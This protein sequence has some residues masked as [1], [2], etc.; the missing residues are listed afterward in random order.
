[1][2]AGLVLASAVGLGGQTVSVAH[3]R[4]TEPRVL[5]LVEQGIA[6]SATFRRLIDALNASD[7][8]VYI[9]PK[10]HRPALGGYLS[11]RMVARGGTR[12]LKIAV[13]VRGGEERVIALVAHELQHAV[14][15]AQSPAVRDSVSMSH[16]FEQAS[17]GDSC[18]GCFE[19]AAAIEMQERVLA[20]LK[21]K[22]SVTTIAARG[23]D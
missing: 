20:E 2:L 5:A 8:I 6:R 18:G 7:V 11:H 16:L 4:T 1:M 13:E 12:Y 10:L 14:E 23:T 15:V 22:L 19:T 9:E 17:I 3:V 21:D